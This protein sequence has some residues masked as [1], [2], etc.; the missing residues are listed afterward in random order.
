MGS[1][2]FEKEII[3]MK[4]VITLLLVI[5]S[6]AIILAGCKGNSSEPYVGVWYGY[7]V[8]TETEEIIFADYAAIIKMELVTEFTADGKYELHY[9]VAGK[10]GNKYP[11]TGKFEM[12]GD[13]IVLIEADGYGEIVNGELIRSIICAWYENVPC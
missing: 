4:K 5:C 9:Y 13:K 8:A 6:F 7:K 2:G 1:F 10:E 3:I 11:Q 12:N